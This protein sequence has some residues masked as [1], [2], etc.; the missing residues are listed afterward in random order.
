ME[1][2]LIFSL[3]IFSLVTPHPLCVFSSLCNV[4]LGRGRY[5][6]TKREDLSPMDRLEV[7]TCPSQSA[8]STTRILRTPKL[9]RCQKGE[10][11]PSTGAPSRGNPFCGF[12]PLIVPSGRRA[13]FPPKTIKS[14]FQRSPPTPTWCSFVPPP[15]WRRFLPEDSL[16]RSVNKDTGIFLQVLTSP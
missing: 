13:L 1:R 2:P 7:R 11:F 5:R 12:R 10:W 3:A 16:K 8:S 4:P 15:N 6:A 14:S 9:V